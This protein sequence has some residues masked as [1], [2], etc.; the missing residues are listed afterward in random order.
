M[1]RI[2]GEPFAAIPQRFLD[3][4]VSDRAIR[5]LAVLNRYADTDGRA[6]PGRPKLAERLRCGVSSLDRAITEL[7][8]VG[9]ITVE[10]HFRADGSR[11]ANSY[12]LWPA[13]PPVTRPLPTGGDTPSPPVQPP[14][15]TERAAIGNESQSIQNQE[16][17]P[18]ALAADVTAFEAFWAAYPRKTAKGD[19]RKAWPAAVKAAGGAAPIITGAMRYRADPNRAAEFTAHASTWLRGERWNDDPLPPRAPQR[20]TRSPRPNPANVSAVDEAYRNMPTGRLD[21]DVDP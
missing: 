13:T 21:L 1:S 9:A 20:G 12:W 18:R 5:L 17:Q 16:D 6:F 2:Y 4:D 7:I 10:P 8:A 15:P 3:S 19:A 11:A 14:L